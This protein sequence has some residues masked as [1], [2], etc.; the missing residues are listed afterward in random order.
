MEKSKRLQLREKDCK[1]VTEEAVAKKRKELIMDHDR[2]FAGD[3]GLADSSSASVAVNLVRGAASSSDSL[4][5]DGASAFQGRFQD[6]NWQ[7]LESLSQVESRDS[8]PPPAHPEEAKANAGDADE[9]KEGGEQVKKEKGKGKGKKQAWD[10]ERI[11]AAK[12]RSDTAA[13]EDLERSLTS[14][15]QDAEKLIKE[16]Q[17]KS[18]ECQ[19]EVQVELNLLS[20]RLA[21]V[22]LVVADDKSALVNK[23]RTLKSK[24]EEQVEQGEAAVASPTKQEMPPTSSYESLLTMGTLR[25][26]IQAYWLCDSSAMLF[27]GFYSLI[28]S[29]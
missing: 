17:D 21:F 2:M 5:G 27:L 15:K 10:K 26:N 29:F 4:A 28:F 7:E 14:K 9:E 22:D 25:Q 3:D 24:Q 1:Q 8:E 19:N 18:E 20:R 12:I 13:L 6:V 23:I 16:L 11:V